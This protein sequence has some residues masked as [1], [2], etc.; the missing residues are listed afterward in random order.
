MPLIPIDATGV[1]TTIESSPDLAIF[2]ETK[3][4]TP[5]TNDVFEVP[6]SVTGSYINSSSTIL[7]PSEREIVVLS[8]K[9]SPTVPPADV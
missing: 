4:K 3:E 5:C 1:S 6:V 8:L 9:I 7:P 2:P